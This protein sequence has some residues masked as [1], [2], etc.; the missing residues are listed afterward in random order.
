MPA[1]V[2][3]RDERDRSPAAGE[4]CRAVMNPDRDNRSR[5]RS[6]GT[7]IVLL[8][9]VAAALRLPKLG[10]RPIWIDE[11]YSVL[12]AWKGPAGI[13]DALT[14]DGSPPLFY[15]V[16]HAWVKLFG[17]SALAVRLLPAIF[18]LM[19]VLA[20]FWLARAL[21]PSRPRA[22]IIAGMM[23]AI[24]PLHIY[25]SQ[26]C[27]MYSLAFLVAV[28]SL[29]TS[30]RILSGDRRK[31]IA[32]HGL[33]LALGLYIHNYFL[34]VV[35]V[36]PLAALASC[37][38]SA[39]R[40]A[41]LRSAGAVAVAV[42]LYA[43]WIPI[44]LAQGRSGVDSWIPRFWSATPPAAALLRSIEAMGVGGVYPT[45]L[46]HMASI[47]EVLPLGWGWVLVRVVEAALGIGL[48]LAGTR[49]AGGSREKVGGRALVLSHL[50]IPT[51]AP[52]LISFTIKPIYLVGRYEMVALPA[53]MLLAAAGLDSIV[54]DPARSRRALG[55]AAAA[56]WL[57]GAGLCA[58][59]VLSAPTTDP[60]RSVAE[61]L[62]DNGTAE[63]VIILP[64][65]VYTP[66]DY[67][68]T[69]WR[70]P[71][72]RIPFPSEVGRHPGWFDY[73][74]AVRDGAR[75]RDEARDLAGRLRGSLGSGGRIFFI[76]S[77]M[78]PAE[79]ND[80]LAGAM[81]SAFGEPEVLGGPG[82]Y[83]VVF[84]PTSSTAPGGD[85]VR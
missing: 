24:S 64:G 33:V 18:G 68:L 27:R 28:L 21:L 44:L 67:H 1:C 16:L 38:G 55:V 36:A 34:F 84:R 12:V 58:A 32:V 70:V 15:L 17:S 9:A 10:G 6:Q 60:E 56:A 3:D 11:A 52:I 78:T 61:V 48:L 53:F 65:Y 62:R 20:V 19:G 4:G 83:I 71:S 85:S 37:R 22:A 31:D 43:P 69:R 39:R 77:V 73:A 46:Q 5:R 25:Y 23:T 66:I 42:L 29:F 2:R 41:A 45:Y 82:I 72:A 76:R 14:R 7:E 49:R 79:V 13:L 8:A 63:D 75:T 40:R 47:R 57:A 30:W 80:W 35:P 59:A 26:Q 74:R 50:L 54:S 51:V 81:T